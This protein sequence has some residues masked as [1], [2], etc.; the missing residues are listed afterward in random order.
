LNFAFESNPNI[1]YL[2]LTPVNMAVAVPAE[3]G[4]CKSNSHHWQGSDGCGTDAAMLGFGQGCEERAGLSGKWLCSMIDRYQLS[5]GSCCL[6]L[7]GTRWSSRLVETS[8]RTNEIEGVTV[9]RSVVLTGS[10]LWEL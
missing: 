3:S 6:C 1:W 5:G 7:H 8:E 4:T 2:D 10:P 9:R